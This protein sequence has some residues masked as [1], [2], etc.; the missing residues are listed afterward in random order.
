MGKIRTD[1]SKRLDEETTSTTDGKSG[2]LQPLQALVSIKHH[3]CELR[4]GLGILM[5]LRLQVSKLVSLSSI[6]GIATDTAPMTRKA[7][8]KECTCAFVCKYTRV[9]N[10]I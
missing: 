2:F 10:S 5:M 7:H 9:Q 6:L 8:P 1:L 4:M 3:F